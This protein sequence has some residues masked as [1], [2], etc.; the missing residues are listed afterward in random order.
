MQFIDLKTQGKRVEEKVLAR[1]KDILE[2]GAY[3]M[4]PEVTELETMLAKFVGVE[5]ALAVA[6]GTDALLIALMAVGV[7]HGDRKYRNWRGNYDTSRSIV[8]NDR[9]GRGKTG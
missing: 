1:I 3:I 9:G 7:G 4:G 5:H 6:S 8:G 2:H